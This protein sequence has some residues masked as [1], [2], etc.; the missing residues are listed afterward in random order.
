MLI[1]W[2]LNTLLQFPILAKPT[3]EPLLQDN[4]KENMKKAID[5]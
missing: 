1:L 5:A 3:A 2:R 4:Q